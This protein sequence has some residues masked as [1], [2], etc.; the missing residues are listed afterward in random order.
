MLQNPT[1]NRYPL[2]KNCK[3]R[4]EATAEKNNQSAIIEALDSYEVTQ[5]NCINPPEKYNEPI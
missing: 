5:R 3:S 4:P 1:K 2:Q